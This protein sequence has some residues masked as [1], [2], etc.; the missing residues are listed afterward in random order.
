MAIAAGFKEQ[1]AAQ[2]GEGVG[3][4]AVGQVSTGRK[5]PH[6]RVAVNGVGKAFPVRQVALRIG[7]QLW[8]K[9]VVGEFRHQHTTMQ[10]PR[11]AQ[12][13]LQIVQLL[14]ALGV[15]IG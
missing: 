6:H 8:L 4:A 13:M 12:Q 1:A 14:T 7:D 2:F 11:G 9:L 5:I 10:Q 3:S 15:Q